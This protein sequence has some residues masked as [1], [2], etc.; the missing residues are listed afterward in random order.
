VPLLHTRDL[1]ASQSSVPWQA[2]QQMTFQELLCDRGISLH[3]DLADHQADMA[4][5]H[6]NN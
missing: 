2:V 5:L 4:S 3:Y 6:D 1:E